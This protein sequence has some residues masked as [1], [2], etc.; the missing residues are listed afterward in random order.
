M[1]NY[2]KENVTPRLKGQILKTA[3]KHKVETILVQLKSSGVS[4]LRAK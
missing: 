3:L 2:R 4:Q 1:L